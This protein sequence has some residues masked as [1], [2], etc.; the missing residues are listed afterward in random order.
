MKMVFALAS[1][2][3]VSHGCAAANEAAVAG[4]ASLTEVI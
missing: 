3:L 4:F 2:C 1:C